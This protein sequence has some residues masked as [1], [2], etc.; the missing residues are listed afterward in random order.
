[1]QPRLRP[2]MAKTSSSST[3]DTAWPAARPANL[4]ERACAAARQR[5]CGGGP[6]GKGEKEREETETPTYLKLKS[7]REIPAKQRILIRLAIS[8]TYIYMCFDAIWTVKIIKCFHFIK[9][10]KELVLETFYVHLTRRVFPRK[11]PPPLPRLF[12]FSLLLKDW[13]FLGIKI[14][15][16]SLL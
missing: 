4:V 14:C 6:Q 10:L 8:H 11:A 5:K 12:L 15:N 16:G 7:N 3:R 9:R 1:M 13:I 2:L